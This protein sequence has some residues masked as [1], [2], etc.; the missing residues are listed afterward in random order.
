MRRFVNLAVAALCLPW[1]ARDLRAGDL[2]VP[3]DT[4]A[5]GAASQAQEPNGATRDADSTKAAG[6]P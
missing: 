6:R 2:Y 4:A 3:I 1:I 5:A